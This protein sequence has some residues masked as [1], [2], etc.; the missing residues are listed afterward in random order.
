MRWR[1]TR[2]RAPEPLPVAPGPPPHLRAAD[3]FGLFFAVLRW[4]RCWLGALNY[5]N[6][7]A[8]LVALLLARRRAGEPDRSRTCSCRN[9]RTRV[10][11]AA[12]PVAAGSPLAL[13]LHARAAP[14]RVATRASAAA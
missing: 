11:A 14:G 4:A 10:A 8:L 3:G 2:P 5:N 6:N 12:E 1:W 7:P 13:R 9:V